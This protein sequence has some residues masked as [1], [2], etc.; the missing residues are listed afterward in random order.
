[1][2]TS[3]NV[4]ALACR[5]KQPSEAS[6]V[7]HAARGTRKHF[8]RKPKDYRDRAPTLIGDP[9]DGSAVGVDPKT[10]PSLRPPFWKT[11]QSGEPA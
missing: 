1:M 3:G 7:L 5:P 6:G 2:T 4:G 10:F 9:L 8:H 11:R